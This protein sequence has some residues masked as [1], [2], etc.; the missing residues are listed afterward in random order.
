[1]TLYRKENAAFFA[2]PVDEEAA[3]RQEIDR[4]D[5]EERRLELELLDPLTDLA[6]PENS[7]DEE[8]DDLPTPHELQERLLDTVT[9]PTRPTDY[10]ALY[11]DPVYRGKAEKKMREAK[12][13]VRKVVDFATAINDKRF[14]D[15]INS[16]RTTYPDNGGRTHLRE[17]IT[18]VWLMEQDLDDSDDSS[19]NSDR[20]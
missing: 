12:K 16:V 3:L 19:F 7:D 13:V 8:E 11:L 17:L 15:H 10:A 1:M 2:P 4:L 5:R 9:F 6:T 14:T 18:L 20:E